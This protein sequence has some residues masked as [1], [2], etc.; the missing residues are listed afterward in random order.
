MLPPSDLFHH[1]KKYQENES[2]G[3]KDR[4][5][6]RRK[7]RKANEKEEQSLEPWKATLKSND[8]LFKGINYLVC[9]FPFDEW[10]RVIAPNANEGN[11]WEEGLKREMHSSRQERGRETETVKQRKGYNEEEKEERISF[12]RSVSWCLSVMRIWL[13][14]HWKA[15]ISTSECC[16]PPN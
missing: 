2:G 9:D 1:L 8:E 15:Q 11:G 16:L 6:V 13:F 7:I 4:P 3:G 5:S 12:N 14:C 10:D